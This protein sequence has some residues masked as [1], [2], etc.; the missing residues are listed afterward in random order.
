MLYYTIL[1][2]IISQYNVLCTARRC[3]SL[4]AV[5]SASTVVSDARTCAGA[6]A[7]ASAAWMLTATSI[8]MHLHA[9]CLFA[10]SCLL[11]C[12]ERKCASEQTGTLIHSPNAANRRGARALAARLPFMYNILYN[13]IIVYVMISWYS[14]VLLYFFETQLTTTSKSC[15]LHK[16]GHQVDVEEPRAAHD[17]QRAAEDLPPLSPLQ[18]S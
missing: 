9:S 4:S 10:W 15:P 7:A 2:C 16:P 3:S 11:G 14:S 13:T 18:P 1:Q 5:V 8:A 6:A 12:A 17:V